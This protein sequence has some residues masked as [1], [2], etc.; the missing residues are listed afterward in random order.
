MIQMVMKRKKHINWV[1]LP[2]AL[3]FLVSCL[4]NKKTGFIRDKN[5]SEIHTTDVHIKM[6]SKQWKADSLGCQ[7]LR[8]KIMAETM[9]DSLKLKNAE[10]MAF[11]EMF[12]SPNRKYTSGERLVLGYYFDSICINKKLIDSVDYCMAEFTF[13]R[14]MLIQQNYICL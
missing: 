6:L 8:T 10:K 4:D 3:F 11:L 7:R 1:F 13:E 2:M 5:V 9:I 12:G 14:N